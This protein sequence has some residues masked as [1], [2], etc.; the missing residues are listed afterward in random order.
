M[1]ATASPARVAAWNSRTGSGSTSQRS[2]AKNSSTAPPTI[3]RVSAVPCHR[4]RRRSRA[5][6]RASS[7]R[8]VPATASAG[9]V[10][11]GCDGVCGFT[12]GRC[13]SLEDRQ[14]LQRDLQDQR[15][16]RRAERIAG[17][18]VALPAA[19]GALLLEQDALDHLEVLGP[20]R[21]ARDVVGLDRIVV[22]VEE[23]VVTAVVS[24]E[25]LQLAVHVVERVADDRA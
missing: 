4:N 12:T 19:V 24:A 11:T 23:E 25:A 13:S 3:A 8:S 18:G 15:R 14:V 16:D 5:S 21:I 20:L 22:A 7:G 17:T 9:P 6:C 10:A 2:S 1:P